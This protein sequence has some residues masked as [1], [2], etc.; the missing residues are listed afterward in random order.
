[1]LLGEPGE[2]QPLWI[3]VQ[4]PRNATPAAEGAEYTG[5]V[6]MTLSGAGDGA[7]V[8]AVVPIMLEVWKVAVPTTGDASV[9]HVWGF[10]AKNVLPFYPTKEPAE[11]A[12]EWWDFMEAHRIPPLEAAFEPFPST[13]HP[14]G[15]VPPITILLIC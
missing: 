8:V 1:M 6:T 5:T 3:T 9:Q 12:Y 13:A 10:G 7:A 2:S 4:V 14:A 15:R 11:V